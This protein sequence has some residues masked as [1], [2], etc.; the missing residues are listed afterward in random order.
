MVKGRS[1]AISKACS[2]SYVAAKVK[3]TDAHFDGQ[4]AHYRLYYGSIHL[5]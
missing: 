3:N 4:V 1:I 5:K 2:L